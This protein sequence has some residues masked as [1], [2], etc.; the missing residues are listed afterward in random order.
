MTL[1]S[2][3]AAIDWYFLSPEIVLTAAACVVLVLDLFLDQRRKHV[4]AFTGALGIAAALGL[5]LSL[6]GSSGRTLAGAFEIDTFALVFKGLLA[7]VGLGVV[8]VSVDHFR[9]SGYAQGE[10]YFLLLCALL[11][12]FLVA[13]ARDLVTLFVSLELVTVP[14]FIMV[15]LRKRD[16]KSNEGAL[17]FFLFG[18]LSTAVMLYGMSLLYGVTGETL[19]GPVGEVLPS[20]DRGLVV[21]AVFFVIV[22]LAFKA[23]AAPFHFWAPDAYE[24]APAPVA[25]YLATISKLSGFIGL[26]VVLTAFVEVADLWRPFIALLAVA[27]MTIG[28]LLALRQ[29]NIIRLLAYSGIA[30][31]GYVL[32]AL[33]LLQPPTDGGASLLTNGSPLV[34]AAFYLVIFVVMELGAFAAAIGFGRRYGSYFIAD[35]AGLWRRSP[36]LAVALAAFLI[37]LAGAPPLAGTWAKLFIFLAALDHGAYF[38]AG[39]MGVNTVIAAWYY[40]AIVRRMFFEEPETDVAVEPP[41]LIRATVVAAGAVLLVLF[42]YPVLVTYLLAPTAGFVLVGG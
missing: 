34:A 18:V 36:L 12:G 39:V 26:I 21:L 20:A 28:N 1:A 2:A 8:A 7:L 6:A 42:V 22:G 10:Y 23:A 32:L 35:Y 40:L 27:S 17:K 37:S 3:N 4:A 13:S 33:A 19:L 38:L 9:A 24:G 14:G 31:S 5:V 41:R 25:A 15:A 16:A 30:Q 11:G 29:D